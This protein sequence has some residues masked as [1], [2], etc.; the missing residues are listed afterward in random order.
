MRETEAVN[1]EEENVAMCSF[2]EV[3]YPVLYLVDLA[4]QFL[5]D[6]VDSVSLADPEPE[7]V[8]RAKA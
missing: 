5:T 3:P 2:Y 4:A 7:L 8:D 6:L 1:K